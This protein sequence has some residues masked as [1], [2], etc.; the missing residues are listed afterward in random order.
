MSTLSLYL[1]WSGLGVMLFYLLER[2]L[3]SKST[4]FTARRV[5][6]LAA[7]VVSLLL[8][9]LSPLLSDRIADAGK[10]ALPAL[11]LTYRLP[12]FFVTEVGSR[13]PLPWESI[14]LGVWGWGTVLYVLRLMGGSLKLRQITAKAV[15]QE[16]LP[17][18]IRVHLIEGEG[19]PFTYGSRHIVIPVDL[20]ESDTAGNAL[21]HEMAHIRGR[22]FIDLY[23]GLF[24]KAIQWWNPFAWGLAALQDSNL[25]YLADA[26]VLKSGVQKRQ[27]QLHLLRSSIGSSA[28][29]LML[30]F[31]M[32]HL[33]KRVTMMNQK[34]R[35]LKGLAAGYAL[36]ALPVAALM[37]MSAS[38]LTAEPAETTPASPAILTQ[39]PDDDPVY[40]YA[41]VMPAYPGGQ[42]AMLAFLSDNIKYP[43][44]AVKKDIQ[45][46]VV[47]TFVVD[48]DGTVTEPKIAHSVHE[49][50]DAEALRVISLMPKWTPGKNDK[51]E[52]VRVRFHLPVTFAFKQTAPDKDKTPAK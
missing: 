26:Q 49:L 17:G 14:L 37:L 48:K 31:S 8:P 12:E 51:G 18:G 40:E 39:V 35:T 1:L 7:I 23:L 47:V 22:H 32:N 20:Y 5:Y 13:S 45:G 9:A 52:T 30:S 34:H 43:E 42:E 2:L 27:Y 29:S 4:L 33:K 10:E 25:E 3:F 19:S 50:L 46:R 41:E 11:T 24:L 16:E 15:G 28:D 38:L 21:R 44:E 6:Y 36:I